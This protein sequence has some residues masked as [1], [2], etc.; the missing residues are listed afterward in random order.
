M[1]FTSQRSIIE[2]SNFLTDIDYEMNLTIE[3]LKEQ[4][5]KLP[6]KISSYKA[7]LMYYPNVVVFY[8]CNKG[9]VIL[10]VLYEKK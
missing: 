3:Q 6:L 4:L 2:F 1:R 7:K 8:L 10:E 9:K 5:N